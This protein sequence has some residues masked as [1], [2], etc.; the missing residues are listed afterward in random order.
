MADRYDQTVLLAYVEGELSDDQ[1]ERVERWMAADPRLR[2]LLD[3]MVADRAALRSL[4]EPAAPAWVMDEVDADLE[5]R[6]LLDDT[7]IDAP[8]A[9]G[10]KHHVI[11]RVGLALGVAAMVLIAGGVVFWSIVGLNQ[12][13]VEYRPVA[14]NQTPAP[15]DAPEDDDAPAAEQAPRIAGAEIDPDAAATD[16]PRAQPPAEAA[17]ADDPV[18]TE[19]APDNDPVYREDPD[20]TPHIVWQV[21]GVQ[22]RGNEQR[23]V[24]RVKTRDVDR[25]VEQIGSVARSIP[26][27]RLRPT[28]KPVVPSA[29]EDPGQVLAE[30]HGGAN[31]TAA[32]ADDPPMQYELEVPPDQLER[33]VKMLRDEPV[34]A[35]HD[36]AL[37]QH[38]DDEALATAIGPDLRRNWPSFAPD[39]RSILRQ[40]VPLSL[41]DADRREGEGPEPSPAVHA[42]VVPIV[43]EKYFADAPPDAQ[44]DDSQADDAAAN[45]PQQVPEELVPRIAPPPSLGP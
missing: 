28:V 26:D 35:Y 16:T 38:G 20:A 39:Y 22:R 32:A 12:N 44:T 4:P 5:R 21:T 37:E 18:A 10:E 27:A 14:T 41:A 34:D 17:P 13:R 43:I 31:T 19:A 15:A 24:I 8:N 40:Q 2:V 45:E 36:V 23:F 25:S 1:R 6:M 42:V 11:G 7:P 33:V 30:H 3:A 29:D 9:A